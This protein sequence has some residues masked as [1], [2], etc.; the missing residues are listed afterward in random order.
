MTDKPVCPYGDPL[1]PCPDGDTC[2]YEWDERTKTHPM[3]PLPVIVRL[4]AERDDA[5][6]LVEEMRAL[7]DG[8]PK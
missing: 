7:M 1:C 8:G 4:T 2:H 6:L 3:S 5:R